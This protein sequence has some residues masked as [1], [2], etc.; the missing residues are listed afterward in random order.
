M[1]KE[2]K[3]SSNEESSE[4]TSQKNANDSTNTSRKKSKP[5]KGK[6]LGLSYKSVGLVCL[7]IV[8]II[9]GYYGIKEYEYYQN[10][11]TTNDAK[12]DGHINPV[13]SRVA[14]YVDSVYVDDNE[15]VHKGQ[16][17]V[18]IDTTDIG[19]Q[20]QMARSALQDAKASLGVSKANVESAKVQLN[21]AQTDYHRVHNLYEGGATTQ[22]KYDDVQTELA[23]AKAS[24]NQVKSHVKVLKKKIKQKKEALENEKLKLSYTHIRARSGGIISKKD[25]REGQ[26]I[27]PG[28]PLMSLTDDQD[29]WVT[30]NFKETGLYDIR[31]GQK[32]KISID[33]YPHKKF[34]GRVASIAGATG[35]KFSLL[36][37]DNATGNYVKV[38]QR[39]PVKIIFTQKPNPKYPIRQGLNVEISIN[40]NQKDTTK[41][42]RA[43]ARR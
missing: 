15:R 2:E 6:I 7:A 24:L 22:A 33:A 17:L 4:N 38:V 31:V 30:A 25:I 41:K 42:A 28:Q 39:V 29:V 10:H 13:L 26:Y 32:A 3:N 40:I 19:L 14:G 11:V 36:P 8:L 21:K 9:G 16:M 34:K 18:Q 27:T 1:S 35:A 5:S 23:S 37:S 43:Q 20:V 12:T